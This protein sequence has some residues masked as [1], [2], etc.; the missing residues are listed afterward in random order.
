M[1]IFIQD[2]SYDNSMYLHESLLT[3]C[4]DAESGVGVYAFATKD[5]IDLILNDSSFKEFIHTGSFLLIIGLDDI[6]NLVAI[7]T[8]KHYLEL[9]SGHLTVFAYVHDSRR[10]TFH[11]KFC[12]FKNQNGGV[13]VVGSGNLT[14]KGLRQ[15]REAYSYL[16]LSKTEFCKVEDQWN[17]WYSHSLSFLFEIENTTVAELAARNQITSHAVSEAKSKAKKQCHGLLLDSIIQNQPKDNYPVNKPSTPVDI[18]EE[19]FWKID[20]QASVLIA[21]IPK[22]GDRW[23]QA[24]FDKNTFESFFGAT[25]GENGQYRILLKSVSSDGFLGDTEPRPS[26]SVQSQ[27]YRFEL[28]AASGLNYPTDGN[29]PIAIFAKVSSRNFL[30]ELIMPNDS[31]YHQISSILDE[32]QSKGHSM[33]RIQFSFEEI[34]S[35]IPSLPLLTFIEDVEDDTF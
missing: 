25:C 29:R 34:Q 17:N 27:N 12:F 13:V 23:K 28:D 33:R 24:N 30:Y 9:Y 1:S 35:R 8:L 2:P 5:G 6:T 19:S 7:N 14:Q 18:E 31:F 21:E 11:P 15:N 3:A 4:K 10:S 22:S 20:T 26:V 32:K 16:E